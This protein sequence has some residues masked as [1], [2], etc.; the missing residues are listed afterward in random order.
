LGFPQS[1]SEINFAVIERRNFEMIGSVTLHTEFTNGV[2]A[3][4]AFNNVLA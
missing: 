4:E 1:S 3:V 2:I